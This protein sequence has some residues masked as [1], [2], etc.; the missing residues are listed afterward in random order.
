MA[1]RYVNL[2]TRDT[3]TQF[4]KAVAQ[5][6]ERSAMRVEP[7]VITSFN[8]GGIVPVYCREVLPTQS[9]AVNLDFII[10]EVTMK[11]PVLGGLVADVYA[12]FV[13]TRIINDEWKE[14]MGENKNGAWYPQEVVLN[15]LYTGSSDVEIPVGSI[16]D[17]YGLATQ[18]AYPHEVLNDMNDLRFRGYFMI[19][20]EEF[21]DQNYQSPLELSL[22]NVTNAGFFAEASNGGISI[23]Q[24]PLKANKFH[25]AFTSVL[26]SPQ[27]GADV[28]LPLAGT[29]PVHFTST[30]N[31]SRFEVGDGTSGELIMLFNGPGIGSVGNYPL[32]LGVRRG[33]D[34]YAPVELEVGSPSSPSSSARQIVGWNIEGNVDFSEIS[35]VT[36]STLREMSAMQ[37][38]YEQLGRVGSRYREYLAGFFGVE[39]QNPM[40]DVPELL[41]HI[42]RELDV[43]QTAQT[44]ASETGNTPQGN[45]AA[46][47]YTR[48]GGRLFANGVFTAVE[49]GFIHYL[50]VVRQKN[51]YPTYTPP[52]MFR[53]SMLDFYQPQFANISEQP[54]PTRVVNP[55][56]GDLEGTFGYQEAWWEYREEPDVVSGLMR[57]GV[58]DSLSS[59]NYADE[60]DSGLQIA[61]DEWLM[62]NAQEVVDRTIAVTSSVSHQ[63]YAWFVFKTDK[64]LPMPVY[65]VPELL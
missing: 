16:A 57:P 42:R 50:V 13:P 46:F 8:A 55:F 10:R 4:E 26:P 6:P 32:T 7:T 34:T 41:G 39:V 9:V 62:S 19:Y 15:A 45:L 22:E 35:S 61:N 21:R 1:D 30:T 51:V 28:L 33:S 14:V 38:F 43:Y 44:S 37:R 47:S 24:P 23:L 3:Q 49:H 48:N 2:H 31:F 58:P 64:E 17:Y 63:F 29:A 5:L 11:T 25:D 20:N 27:K 18:R 53:R 54:I 65:S 52:D 60:F 36:M 56:V 59:W 12:Y 40:K